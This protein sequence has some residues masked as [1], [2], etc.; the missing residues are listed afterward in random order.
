MSDKSTTTT[1]RGNG[2]TPMRKQFTGKTALVTG[3]GTG[4]GRAAALGL[5]A[6]GCTVT[7]AGRTAAT[8]EDTVCAIEAIGGNARY[9]VCD[10]TVESTVAAAVKAAVGDSGK[11]DFAVNS[12]GIVGGDHFALTADYSVQTFDQM[13]ATNVRGMFLS[14]KY[15]LLQM[16]TQAFGSIVNIS[17]GAGLVG[18][19]G[20]SGYSATKFAE[21]GMTKS[22]AIEYAK[23]GI[24]INAICPGLVDTPSIAKLLEAS[25]DFASRVVDS[26]PIGRIAKASEIADAVVWLC[27]DRSSYL[28]GA[29]LPLDGG[30]TAQ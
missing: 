15:E 30:Y 4:I 21:I 20:Y 23:R 17:S 7:V 25:R 24:R 13:I 16:Q 11:L 9:A 26:H 12:A 2:A 8:L 19:A 10:V 6:E 1:D 27:S 22:S 29:A 18:I 14:M 3:G 28:I 5:A